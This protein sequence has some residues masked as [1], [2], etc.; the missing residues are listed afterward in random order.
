M[1]TALNVVAKSLTILDLALKQIEDTA[2]RFGAD[3]DRLTRDAY[4]RRIG[5]NAFE[6]NMLG[7]LRQYLR[8]AYVEGFIESGLDEGDIDTADRQAMTA[9]ISN[10]RQYI[11]GFVAAVMDARDESQLKPAIDARV[12]YWT[13]SIAAMGQLARANAQPRKRWRWVLGKSEE[14]CLGSNS[15]TELNGQVHTMLWYVTRNL[16]PQKPAA[17]MPCSGFNCQCVLVE[18]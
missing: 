8:E 10:Q 15:C 5:A 7:L 6:A 9:E 2:N 12:T 16:I 17:S 11:D 1:L 3:L 18:A 13:R 4:K 14:H